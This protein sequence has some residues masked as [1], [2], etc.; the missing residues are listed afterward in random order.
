M[1]TFLAHIKVHEGKEKRERTREKKAKRRDRAF[2]RD[3]RG[4]IVVVDLARG[5]VHDRH[6]LARRGLRR[7]EGAAHRCSSRALTRL[8]TEFG[9]CED[10]NRPCV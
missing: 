3:L 6:P 10:I 7:A 5:G 8:P 1:A 9:S 2:S 4:R